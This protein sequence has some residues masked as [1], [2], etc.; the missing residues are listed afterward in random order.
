MKKNPHSIIYFF[1]G[2]ASFLNTNINKEKKSREWYQGLLFTKD[3]F[4][5][6]KLSDIVF[7]CF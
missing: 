1:I 2:Y 5:K 6:F 3:F 7:L 4:I